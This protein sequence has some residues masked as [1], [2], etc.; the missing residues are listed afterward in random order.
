[1]G[2]Q[3]FV[4]PVD[5]DD[6]MGMT[7]FDRETVGRFVARHLLPVP[8]D[9][10]DADDDAS[11]VDQRASTGTAYIDP[12]G[13]RVDIA[14]AAIVF[15]DPGTAAEQTVF[16]ALNEVGGIA[17]DPEQA[18][19]VSCDQSWLQTDRS[20]VDTLVVVSTITEMRHAMR[21]GGTRSGI[22]DGRS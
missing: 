17:I 5:P 10:L 13:V 20:P 12:S 14:P 9:D 18:L 3:L 4:R 1:M 16:A 6:V 22:V 11:V 19:A 15:H 8:I 7:P 2:E 21:V